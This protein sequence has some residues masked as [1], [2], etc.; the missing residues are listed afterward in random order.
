MVLKIPIHSVTDLITNSS[1]TIFTYSDGSVSAVRDMVNEFFQTFGITK[2]FDEVFDAVIACEESDQYSE[3]IGELDEEE[4]PE[5]VTKETD[6]KKLFDDVVSGKIE[7]PK[8]FSDVENKEDSWSYFTPST[9]LYLIPKAPEYKELAKKIEG[10]LYSTEH[11][12][13]RDG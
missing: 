11:E 4:L 6:A 3:Y 8:W 1:T 12:G 5:G 7:K 9:T 10:F 13:I 2:K